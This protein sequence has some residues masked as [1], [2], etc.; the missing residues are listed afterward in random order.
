MRGQKQSEKFGKFRALETMLTFLLTLIIV[1]DRL[2]SVRMPMDR[3][4]Y[5]S[6]IN[7]NLSWSINMDTQSM[8]IE[9][10]APISISDDFSW[11]AFG[12]SDTGGMKGADMALIS[13]YHEKVYD[14][15]SV[16]FV[17][18]QMDKIQNWKL[19]LLERFDTHSIIQIKRHLLTCDEEDF[20]IKTD[21]LKHNLMIAYNKND[22]LL[23]DTVDWRLSISQHPY[24]ER[25]E[26]NLFVKET[27]FL[28]QNDDKSYID[29]TMGNLTLS[30]TN[31]ITQYFCQLFNVTNPVYITGFDIL[32]ASDFNLVHHSEILLCKGYNDF[33]PSPKR[34]GAYN[35]RYEMDCSLV[36]ALAAGSSVS[37]PSEVYYLLEPGIYNLEIHFDLN[38]IQQND[39]DVSGSG[40][41]AHYSDI[42]RTHQMGLIRME[43]GEFFIPPN[44]KQHQLSFAMHS[45]CT[46]EMLP[47]QG[48]DIIFFGGHMHY[49][50]DKIRVDRIRKPNSV[51]TVFEIKKWDFDRQFAYP[52]HYTLFRGDTLRVTCTYDSSNTN[53]E[54]VYGE[55]SWN[56]MCQVYV[57]YVN[58][59]EDFNMVYSP[60]VIGH[61][62][63]LYPSYCGPDFIQFWDEIQNE[64]N[65]FDNTHLYESS[66]DNLQVEDD[67]KELCH[68]LVYDNIDF[69]PN[70]LLWKYNTAQI[71]L[72]VGIFMI[73]GF[74]ILFFIIE[75][76][77]TWLKPG[78]YAKFINS[79][80]DKRKINIYVVSILFT[81]VLLII[82]IIE[83]VWNSTN[84]LTGCECELTYDEWNNYDEYP[85]GITTCSNLLIIFFSIELFYRLKVT[86]DLYLHHLFTIAI[87]ITL[88]NAVHT[89]L[90]IGLL[91]L[92]YYWLL[93]VATE[94]PI[95]IAL[96]IRKL[97]LKIIKEENYPKLFYFA[98]FWHYFTKISTTIMIWYHYILMLMAES[99]SRD[100][101]WYVYDISY[102]AFIKYDSESYS[103]ELLDWRVFTNF[104]IGIMSILLFILQMIQGYFFYLLGKP[105][106]KN[107]N[108][109]EQN[110]LELVKAH[111]IQDKLSPLSAIST[112]AIGSHSPMEPIEINGVIPRDRMPSNTASTHSP[113]DNPITPFKD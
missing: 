89:T 69:I 30:A 93:Q 60:P 108:I 9:M 82:L 72:F 32:D 62:K 44:K 83:I 27:L 36:I 15:H 3:I 55:N 47:E 28:E 20:G 59:I 19:M 45:M 41:R 105:S 31:G 99:G 111:V 90:S 77:L 17:L 50:G 107:P 24:Y 13:L 56:E 11:I 51:Q 40:L 25:K 102:S 71:T 23:Q 73:I 42:R 94:Q 38:Q 7:V 46:Q 22:Q 101:I 4:E 1:F 100:S 74:L 43:L 88:A 84:I 92:G 12:L 75:Q 76:I 54:T 61:N 29:Y 81:T 112:H 65:I 37:L 52:V 104:F 5:F 63:V 49:L 14:L 85:Y 86:W 87:I 66:N 33:D 53:N 110:V 98:C 78:I 8:Y 113:S 95:F 103:I 64:T 96:L 34:C 106:N 97:K 35:Y 10:V 58:K 2:L 26:V 70:D 57:G 48:I 91:K 68:A 67:T 6:K 18:P 79:I 109:V 80:E 21:R 16:D 39:V